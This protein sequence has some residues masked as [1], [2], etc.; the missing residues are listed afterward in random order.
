MVLFM[1]LYQ[2]G[3]FSPTSTISADDFNLKAVTVSVSS[4]SHYR[5]AFLDVNYCVQI[6]R[7]HDHK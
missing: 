1:L 4:F 2:F 7:T 5:D 6:L 3:K